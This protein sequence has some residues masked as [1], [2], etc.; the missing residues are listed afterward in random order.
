MKTVYYRLAKEM[1][2]LMLMILG[3]AILAVAINIFISPYNLAFGGVTGITIIVKGYT[4]IPIAFSNFIISM[5]IITFGGIFLGREFML[6]SLIPS[7]MLPVFLALTAKYQPV[8]SNMLS[9]A[10]IGAIIA[11]VGIGLT[12]SAGGSTAG[13]DTIGLILQNYYNIPISLTMIIIDTVVIVLGYRTYGIR[14]ACYS[15]MVAIIMN[16]SVNIVRAAK[17]SVMPKFINS[18]LLMLNKRK[19]SANHTK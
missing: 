15:V 10:V 19:I 9:S 7:T 5:T 18:V 4:G 14:T 3:N 13:P 6:K 11:G 1:K 17:V 2:S 12:I 8:F 16:L